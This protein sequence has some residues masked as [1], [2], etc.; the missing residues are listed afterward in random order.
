MKCD[1]PISESLMI[2]FQL[3][4]SPLTSNSIHF[5]CF[6]LPDW[7]H[8]I[9][10]LC[11]V[12]LGI[13]TLSL[14]ILQDVCSH[15]CMQDQLHNLQKLLLKIIKNLGQWQHNVK[16]RKH[17]AFSREGLGLDFLLKQQLGQSL[18]PRPQVPRIFSLSLQEITCMLNLSKILKTQNM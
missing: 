17:R 3:L 15:W 1:S 5:V 6:I 8:K 16:S 10:I 9:C 13:F 14:H 18:L 11:E 7:N 4:K 2:Q 12:L